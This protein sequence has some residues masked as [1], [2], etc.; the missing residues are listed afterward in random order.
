LEADFTVAW[1]PF[2][3][4]TV[5]GVGQAVPNVAAGGPVAGACVLEWTGL[6]TDL[7]GRVIQVSAVDGG[8]YHSIGY[9]LP[10]GVSTLAK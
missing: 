3:D 7:Q 9:L 6:P 2:G 10:P 8:T 4:D 5:E 1:R